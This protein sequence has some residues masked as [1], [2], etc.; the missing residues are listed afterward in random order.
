VYLF[1]LI[2][3]S[4]RVIAVYNQF[5]DIPPELSTQL[6]IEYFSN[7][8]H[9]KGWNDKHYKCYQLI[10]QIEMLPITEEN[11]KRFFFNP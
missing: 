4:F 8:I 5:K 7:W 3:Y 11:S 6:S 1:S 2:F 9:H 10:L